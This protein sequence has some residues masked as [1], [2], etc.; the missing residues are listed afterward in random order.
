MS[1]QFDDKL[2][3]R[4]AALQKRGVKFSADTHNGDVIVDARAVFMIGSDEHVRRF[5]SNQCAP[6]V[7][8]A[9]SLVDCEDR[10]RAAVKAA[11]GFVTA[12]KDY[13]NA[14]EAAP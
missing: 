5:R 12:I 7:E 4:A 9:E 13:A 8:W 2:L 6:A 1:D 3:A 10:R 14:P 11:Q